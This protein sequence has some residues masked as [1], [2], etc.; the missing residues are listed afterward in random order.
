M[1]RICGGFL[2]TTQKWLFLRYKTFHI[3]YIPFRLRH[4]IN[5]VFL[6]NKRYTNEANSFLCLKCY[7]KKTIGNYSTRSERTLTD[8]SHRLSLNE[9][10]VLEKTHEDVLRE[11]MFDAPNRWNEMLVIAELG[12]TV[13]Q[14]VTWT[15]MFTCRCQTAGPAGRGQVWAGGRHQWPC[16]FVCPRPSRRAYTKPARHRPDSARC[17]HPA[18]TARP[19]PVCMASCSFG[20]L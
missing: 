12:G 10:N 1:C 5:T 20:S 19:P 11:D 16:G 15:R 17:V 4:L 7:F 6:L 14:V 18:F 13:T 2:L 9:N 8:N 3:I